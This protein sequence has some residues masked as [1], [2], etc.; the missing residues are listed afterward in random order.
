[1]KS[2][3]GVG[4]GSPDRPQKVG[5]RAPGTS[6]P[7]RA[8]TDGPLCRCRPRGT[9]GTKNHITGCGN[10]P[11]ASSC[12]SS[13]VSRRRVRDVACPPRPCALRGCP[14]QRRPCGRLASAAPSR[15]SIRATRNRRT[16]NCPSLY[17]L[18][19]CSFLSVMDGLW[20]LW[21]EG[22]AVD[23]GFIVIHGRRPGSPAGWPGELSTSP[24]S[25]VFSAR[26]CSTN[27]WSWLPSGQ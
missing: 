15:S 13:R 12:A 1:M 14:T 2:P 7:R 24:Q 27:Q 23:N 6:S 5:L 25:F 16:R 19:R 11:R 4:L 21:A 10:G 20:T 26:H 18:F 8:R 3:G 17:G 22:R 9:A